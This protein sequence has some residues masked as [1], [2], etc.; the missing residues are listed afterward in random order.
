MKTIKHLFTRAIV[1]LLWR[2]MLSNGGLLTIEDGE[3]WI[4]EYMPDCGDFTGPTN[5][6]GGPF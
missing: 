2:R 4:W 6:N 1:W 3:G 5:D